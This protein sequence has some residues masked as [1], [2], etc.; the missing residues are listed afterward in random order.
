MWEPRFGEGHE[1]AKIEV[2]GQD[3]VNVFG[4]ELGPG[5]EEAAVDRLGQRRGEAHDGGGPPD[6]DA[7]GV[8]RVDEDG[9]RAELGV[10]AFY[11]EEVEGGD[12]AVLG[13]NV[14]VLRSLLLAP[15]FQ[16]SYQLCGYSQ[17]PKINIALLIRQLK[18]N[19]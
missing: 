15:L 9:R 13:G 14:G 6:G 16:F 4:E 1:G 8:D 2:V 17:P 12:V 11:C 18:I 5:R 3:G 19:K 7:V 10:A